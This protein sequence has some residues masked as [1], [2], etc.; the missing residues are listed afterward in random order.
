MFSKYNLGTKVH[1]GCLFDPSVL[2][3]CDND[4]Q[5]LDGLDIPCK[6]MNL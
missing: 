3:Y 1:D 6:S 5:V 4:C 2:C